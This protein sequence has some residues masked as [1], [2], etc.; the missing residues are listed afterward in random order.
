MVSLE[1]KMQNGGRFQC[2]LSTEAPT[3]YTVGAYDCLTVR[4]GQ[5]HSL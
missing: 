2:V 3:E 5:Q 1:R 4:T